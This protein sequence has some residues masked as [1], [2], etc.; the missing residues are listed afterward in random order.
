MLIEVLEPLKVRLPGG[1]LRD[2]LP[3]QPVDLP[4]EAARKLLQRAPGRARV[5]SQPLLTS[6][7]TSSRPVYFETMAGELL[8]PAVVSHLTSALDSQGKEWAWFCLDYQ[9]S[10][11]WVREDRLRSKPAS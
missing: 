11:L 10:W 9:G 8:G 7:S 4:D 5:A 1:Q 2:L 3:G 6:V